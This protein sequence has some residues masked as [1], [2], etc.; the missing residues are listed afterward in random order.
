MPKNKVNTNPIEDAVNTAVKEIPEE[1]VKKPGLPK[2]TEEVFGINLRDK[3][4]FNTN[5]I[6]EHYNSWLSA[7][8]ALKRIAESAN[9]QDH[10]A[11]Q[12]HLKYSDDMV[13]AWA[14]VMD[15][16]IRPDAVRMLEFLRYL[17]CYYSYAS[18]KIEMPELYK[19]GNM[20]YLHEG[21]VA[22]AMMC[23]MDC[24]TTFKAEINLAT[25]IMVYLKGM[26]KGTP[27]EKI[28]LSIHN[29]IHYKDIKKTK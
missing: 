23:L 22:T 7:M 9:D 19:Y 14:H 24:E 2:I 26:Q 17:W 25:V 3:G 11:Y 21:Q 27:T 16:E 12:H 8:L 28:L 29:L 1:E 13:T 5:Y 18:L 6:P 20:F 4:S 10:L 15:G